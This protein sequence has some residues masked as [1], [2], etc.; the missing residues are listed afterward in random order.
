MSSQ[1]DLGGR[2]SQE[3]PGGARSSQKEPKGAFLYYG[4]LRATKLSQLGDAIRKKDRKKERKKE[5]KKR[6]SQ[7][8]PGEAKRSQE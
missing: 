8:E 6:R 3:K 7:E 1:K 5:R 4:A 2:S